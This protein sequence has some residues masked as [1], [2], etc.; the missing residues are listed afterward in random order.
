MR[1]EAIPPRRDWRQRVEALGFEFHTLDGPYWV[2][3]ACYRFTSDE[4]DAIDDATAELHR[5]C[6]EAVAHVVRTGDYAPLGLDARAAALVERS[7]R[8]N[9]AS[10]YGRMD[11]AFGPDGVPKLLEYNADTPTALF[12]AS[13]VQW[14]WLEETRAGRDQFN[15]VHERLVERWPQVV[16]AGSRV[17]FAGCLEVVEDRVTLEY[18]A[19]TARQAGLSFTL[20]DMPDIGWRDGGFVDLDDVPIERMFKLYPWEWMLDEPFAEHLSR[21]PTQ[22]IEPAWKQVLS[23]KSLL[24][25]LWRLFPR[26]PNLL[27]ASHDPNDIG[28]RMVAKPRFGREGEGVREVGPS[29]AFAQDGMVY[30]AWAPLHESTGGHALIGSWLVGDAPAGIGVREDDGA[31]TTNASRFVPH[32]FD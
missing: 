16:A 20:L 2:D 23:N 25:L 7:W 30:Q 9:E 13:V 31:I 1:R 10:L 15:Q 14:Y 8:T 32:C 18:L 12:E 5:M 28:G 19:E 29:G 11:L 21:V 3:D 6:L 27:A 17:H 24:P 22:W 26:H 4:I